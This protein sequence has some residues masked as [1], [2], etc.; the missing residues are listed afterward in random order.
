[1][2]LEESIKKVLDKYTNC[3]FNMASDAARSLLTSELKQAIENRYL[4]LRKNELLVK[5]EN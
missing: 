5:D 4:I 1:M 2:K 3:Q